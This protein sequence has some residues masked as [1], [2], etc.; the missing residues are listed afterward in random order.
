MET[1][2]LGT[3]VGVERLKFVF[4]VC[5]LWPSKLSG[6]LAMLY[7]FYSLTIIVV[8]L[9]VYDL[10]LTVYIFFIEDV[11]EATN[12]LCMSLTLIT[13][14][15]K[16]L[17]FKI[18]SRRIQRLLNS[19]EEFR[20][21]NDQETLLAEQRIS[22][23][24]KLILFLYISANGAGSAIYSG[25]ILSSEVRLPFLAWFPI[26][27]KSNYTA[28]V[29]LYIYQ[30]IG[31]TIQSNLNVTM[32]LFSAY[33]MHVASIKLEILGRR[34]ENLSKFKEQGQFNLQVDEKTE[35]E[36]MAAL[37]KCVVA[38]QHIWK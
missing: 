21:E 28:Y 16:V 10:S 29:S 30:V 36:H 38:Y 12:S 19:V 32:D 22:F 37:V 7:N 2:K 17:N 5:G 3:S 20:L 25:T 14:F 23:Y 4:N 6:W 33:L 15:G 31:M 8:F 26:D 18:F 11:Q 1:K 24:N 9:F 35:A 13:L 34:L 27:W